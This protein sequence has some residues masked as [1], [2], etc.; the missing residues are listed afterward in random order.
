[1]FKSKLQYI[2]FSELNF[3]YPVC[4]IKIYLSNG[5][6]VSDTFSPNTHSSVNQMLL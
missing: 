2:K 6:I 1:M 3:S 5:P 4:P